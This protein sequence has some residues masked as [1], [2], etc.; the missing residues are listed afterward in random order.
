MFIPPSKLN[1][2]VAFNFS[3]L[4]SLFLGYG[5]AGVSSVAYGLIARECERFVINLYFSL[6]LLN[7]G[8]SDGT[9]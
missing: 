7:L 2:N 6:F 1:K 4:F 9:V 5:C 8:I 3:F